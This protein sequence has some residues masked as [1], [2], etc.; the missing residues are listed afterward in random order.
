MLLQ[1]HRRDELGQIIIDILPALPGAWKDGQ[2]SGLRA[3]GGYAVD[4]A[5]TNG[6]VTSLTIHNAIEM[7]AAPVVVNVNGKRIEVEL[8]V[9][10]SRMIDLK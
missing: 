5:W 3:R 4:L 6:K 2:V 7:R 9:G 10:A 8:D 1:S